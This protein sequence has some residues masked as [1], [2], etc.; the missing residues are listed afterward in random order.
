MSIII[1]KSNKVLYNTLKIFRPIIL[2]NILSKIIEKIIIK[3][4]QFHALSNN[5]VKAESSRLNFFSFLF[6][7]YFLFFILFF[8]FYF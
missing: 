3:R 6:L 5:I 7:F 2:L 1:S 8:I 4:L